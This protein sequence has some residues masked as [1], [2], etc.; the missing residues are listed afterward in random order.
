MRQRWQQ[1][2]NYFWVPRAVWAVESMCHPR[3]LFVDDIWVPRGCALSKP[4]VTRDNSSLMISQSL[5]AIESRHHPWQQFVDD[6]WVPKGCLGCRIHASALIVVLWWFRNPLGLCGQSN[7]CL[8]RENSSLMIFE[9]LGLSNPCVS[10]DS[11]SL[12]IS[13]SLGLCGLSNP[14][15]TRDSWSLMI[16]ESLGAVESTRHPW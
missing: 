2:V 12:I 6:Y 1:F 15:V 5:G 7:P 9:S 16:S 8:T 14:C 13:E 4:C 10:G 11:N 3:Q